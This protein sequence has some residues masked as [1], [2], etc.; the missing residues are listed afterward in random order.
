MPTWGRISAGRF[1]KSSSNETA[2][3]A[4]RGRHQRLI[5]V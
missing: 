2:A 5:P 4:A 1:L 3:T